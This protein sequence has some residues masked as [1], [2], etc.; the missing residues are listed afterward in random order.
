MS[1]FEVKNVPIWPI[2]RQQQAISEGVPQ[3]REGGGRGGGY[4]L[5]GGSQVLP[6]TVMTPPVWRVCIFRVVII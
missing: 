1:E 3:G 5:L 4:K 2:A 6:I